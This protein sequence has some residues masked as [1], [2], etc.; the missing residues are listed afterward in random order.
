MSALVLALVVMVALF[1][2][3]IFAVVFLLRLVDRLF[4]E[5]EK[6]Q[7]HEDEWEE[8]SQNRGC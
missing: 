5:K 6:G 3:G 2:F 4:P 8:T 7:E 1:A